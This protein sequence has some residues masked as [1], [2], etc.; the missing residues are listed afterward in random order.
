MRW[1]LVVRDKG[2][3]EAKMAIVELK[4][5]LKLKREVYHM[6]KSSVFAHEGQTWG[7]FQ[8]CRRKGLRYLN[9]HREKR[10]KREDKS[11]MRIICIPTE[12]KN[13]CNWKQSNLQRFIFKY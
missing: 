12:K 8:E 1:E 13:H 9:N 4:S 5:A 11:H 6:D 2:W 7:S 10:N 3:K